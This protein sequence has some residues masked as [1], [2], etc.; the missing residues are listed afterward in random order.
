MNRCGNDERRAHAAL[1]SIAPTRY[2]CARA[3]FASRRD[4]LCGKCGQSLPRPQSARGL[5]IFR[6]SP[7]ALRTSCE[8]DEFGVGTG[9]RPAAQPRRHRD[10]LSARLR[11]DGSAPRRYCGA[12]AWGAV[13]VRL[14]PRAS[15]ERCSFRSPTKSS[16]THSAS[17]R[18]RTRGAPRRPLG[19]G[20][21]LATGS[22]RR[23]VAMCC[24]TSSLDWPR[25]TKNLGSTLCNALPQLT[26]GRILCW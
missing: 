19:H 20:A 6:T 10:S 8:P 14:A 13:V 23:R 9:T 3:A 12:T 18:C 11:R 16:R 1:G 4:E 2:V 21:K 25:V 22:P 26:G 5:H 15:H 17:C 7:R 24:G